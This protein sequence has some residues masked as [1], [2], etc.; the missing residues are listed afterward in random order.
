MD[1]LSNFNQYYIQTT[2]L[3]IFLKTC[4]SLHKLNFRYLELPGLE[5]SHILNLF[6]RK[7]IFPM[8]RMYYLPLILFTYVSNCYMVHLFY[9]TCITRLISKTFSLNFSCQKSRHNLLCKHQVLTFRTVSHP[10]HFSFQTGNF[11]FGLIASCNSFSSIANT[12]IL[13][14]NIFTKL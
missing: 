12:R 4:L 14:S 2:T 7:I 1:L 11:Y 13:F 8:K 3:T 6:F 5:E 10:F 9:T